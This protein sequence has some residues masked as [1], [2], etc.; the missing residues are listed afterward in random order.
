MSLEE[1]KKKATELDIT[2]D[3]ETTEDDLNVLISEKEEE[4]SS[5]LDYLKKEKIKWEEEAKKA[6]K[7]RDLAAS[8]KRKL[9]EKLKELEDLTKDSVGKDELEALR[10]EFEELKKY[11]EEVEKKQEEEELKKV[12][13]VERGKI[14]FAKQMDALKKQ[15]DD[16]KTSY[17]KDLEEAQKKEKEQLKA[18]ESLRGN[19]LES[20]ILRAA[21][22]SN[23]YNP[24][25]IVALTK[26]FF[27]Y[28]EQLDKY[29]NLVRDVG[30]KIV[31]ELS[32]DEYI[33]TFLGREENENLVKSGAS[34][35]SF[36]TKAQQ[37]A[38]TISASAG[39]GKYKANDPQIIKEAEDKHLPPADWAEI[40]EKMEVKQAALREKK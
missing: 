22:K 24:D 33:K 32:V 1:L 25:Q 20:D 35:S 5:D 8:E 28:D 4:L 40:K 13:D 17:A 15:M 12:D 3:D 21:A 10:T 39:K 34:S 38:D 6:F 16:M 36:D 18:I 2:F 37:R 29:S 14:Q 11:K 30:G 23:A 7:K 27:T 19:R 31:D 9:S 26:G